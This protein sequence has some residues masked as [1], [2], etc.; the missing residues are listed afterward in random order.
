RQR[1]LYR[2]IDEAAGVDDH[3]VGAGVG[4]ARDVALGA[5]L[6]EDALGVDQRFRT[7]VRDEPD[8]RVTASRDRSWFADQREN[9]GR[10]GP[11]TCC[12]PGSASALGTA[13][14]SFGSAPCTP[15]YGS[16]WPGPACSLTAPTATASPGSYC[17]WS[18]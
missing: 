4:L 10:R 5:Q 3:Q 6:R 13:R 8:F 14:T 9:Q 11:R 12:A 1:F 16:A 17:R 18:G 2:G 15:A 7:A